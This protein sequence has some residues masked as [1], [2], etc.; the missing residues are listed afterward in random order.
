MDSKSVWNT[1]EER[2]SLLLQQ[3]AQYAKLFKIVSARFTY[4]ITIIV[5]IIVIT[6]Y[7]YYF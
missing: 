4:V 6:Q 3:L 7:Y 1:S 2:P 5:A